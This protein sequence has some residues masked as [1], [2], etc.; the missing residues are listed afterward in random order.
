M[1]RPDTARIRHRWWLLSVLL[2][3]LAG[4]LGSVRGLGHPDHLIVDALRQFDGKP[5]RQDIVVIAID[6]ASLRAMGP[7]PWGHQPYAR[8]LEVLADAEPR[9]VGITATWG[10]RYLSPQ[11]D[12]RAIA[13]A[14]RQAGNVV[15]PVAMTGVRGRQ[16]LALPPSQV[17]APEAEGIG[18]IHAPLDSDGVVRTVALHQGPAEK[19]W[20]HLA[21][22]M[23]RL[24]SGN[25][26]SA[27]DRAKMLPDET[28]QG[29][30]LDGDRMVV[31]FPKEPVQ[32]VSFVNVVAGLVPV[33]I[34]RNRYVLVGA[35]APGVGNSFAT[36][37]KGDQLMPETD[38]VA[39]V[40]QA[41]LDQH[42]VAMAHPVVNAVANALPVA[43]GVL[44]VALLPTGMA[45]GVLVVLG[46]LLLGA[47]AWMPA[48]AGMQIFPLGGLIALALALPLWLVMR[49]VMELRG[50]SSEMRDMPVSLLPLDST[51][52]G[53]DLVER[54]IGRLHEV[55]R[56]L[57]VTQQLLHE[58]I[59]SVPDMTFIVDGDGR[60]LLTNTALQ[61]SL[62]WAGVTE[63][64]GLTLR[65]VSDKLLP[66]EA[67][68]QVAE[69]FAQG[70]LKR[71]SIE[72][73][74]HD[75]RGYLVRVI[76]RKGPDGLPAG[77]LVSVI[78]QHGA[79]EAR[80]QRDEAL[81][82]ISHDLR[83]PQASILSLLELRSLGA[84]DTKDTD[85]LLE[86]IRRYARTGM[87]LAEDFTQLARAEFG[88][89]EYQRED[90]YMLLSEAA[91]LLWTKADKRGIRIEIPDEQPPAY[92]SVDRTLMTR[93]LR[94]LLENAV[95]FSPEGTAIR[96]DITQSKESRF[97]EVSVRDEGPG[98]PVSDME[99]MFEKF[100]R[101]SGDA[102]VEGSGLGL[103]FVKAVVVSHGGTIR[104]LNC[105][106]Q[107]AEFIIC[108]PQDEAG[109]QP[110][111]G[112]KAPHH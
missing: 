22:A 112:A 3:L 21:L 28:L 38:F 1:V 25:A 59:D 90:L 110:P 2:L 65:D 10:R 67:R 63:L 54:H 39:A 36:P 78:D 51:S 37:A 56:Q 104:A 107:G 14:M 29:N 41:L 66:P 109:K 31:P 70:A 91:D 98:I 81:V 93:A 84:E 23:H 27:L 103:A 62:R 75:G 35:T 43:A 69:L 99:L 32:Q 82:F 106:E 100:R 34:L 102:R 111:S 58:S 72:I 44:A 49:V 45:F 95:R 19:P 71:T 5:R 64:S 101:G 40:L 55:I 4:G 76:P 11:S 73:K 57:R 18:H 83:S 61:K 12:E 26:A 24:G 46:A 105:T 9:V 47:T 89:Y 48:V 94:N 92:A 88:H 87:D 33:D 13:Q 52:G 86:R 60:V 80:R 77:W 68:Q 7:L 53:G 8:L 42:Y 50:I 16:P 74:G 97:W 6:D 79:H 20:E 96:C 85:Q 108:V 30:W 15:L 17:L